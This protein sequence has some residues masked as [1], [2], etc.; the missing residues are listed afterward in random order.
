MPSLY[1]IKP[2]F[3]ALL[4]PAAA[5]LAEA[6]VG[7]NA[8]T[9]AAAGLSVLL[10]L[11]TAITG[12]SWMLLLY[13]PFLLLRMALNAVDGMLAR[14]FFRPTPLG[15]L[16]NEVGDMVSDAALYLP[17]AL[18]LPAPPWLV[19]ITILLAMIGEAAG[20]AARTIGASRRYDGPF[21][22][23]DRALAFSILAVAAFFQVL[24]PPLWMP[25][26]L[27]ALLLLSILT[28]MNR[29]RA[30]LAEIGV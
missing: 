22:K 11:V 18:L 9:L 2:R 4:R 16:L 6:G 14:E 28:I 7:A 24:A 29:V 27:A 3:Q 17:L 30:A 23:S 13:P 10:G 26:V 25:L 15:A 12:W 1:D 21:G 5:R 19:V 8:L 20:I